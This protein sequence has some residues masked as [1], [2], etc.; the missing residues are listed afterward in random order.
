MISLAFRRV[1]NEVNSSVFLACL[2]VPQRSLN[3]SAPYWFF[4]VECVC[5][6]PFLHTDSSW[7]ITLIFQ[8]YRP[9]DI[10]YPIFQASVTAP[11]PGLEI[12][13]YWGVGWVIEGVALMV[14]L[15]K[16][17]ETAVL[18]THLSREM[19]NLPHGFWV[20]IYPGG[21]NF[22]SMKIMDLS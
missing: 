19:G 15:W 5:V 11:A 16:M 17:I 3:H 10:L 18:W 12:S 4:G 7:V 6:T 2:P 1:R 20:K 21:S 22:I 9:I 14:F 13:G 8:A